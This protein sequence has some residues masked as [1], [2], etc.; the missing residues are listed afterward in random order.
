MA[1][2][3]VIGSAVN[4]G[5]TARMLE[6]SDVPARAIG[7]LTLDY[8]KILAKCRNENGLEVVAVFG[9]DF[10][11]GALDLLRELRSTLDARVRIHVLKE[12][13]GHTEPTDDSLETIR[14]DEVFSL[15][16]MRPFDA[17]CSIKQ[18]WFPSGAGSA[19]ASRV[20]SVARTGATV[21]RVSARTPTQAVPRGKRTSPLEVLTLMAQRGAVTT[22]LASE[23][24]KPERHPELSLQETEGVVSHASGPPAFEKMLRIMQHN[25]VLPLKPKVMSIVGKHG[26]VLELDPR[27]IKPLPDNPRWATNPGFSPESLRE[28]AEGIQL[29]GQAEAGEVCPIKGDPDFDAQLID[30]ERRLR[31]C[32]IA[33]VMFRA[34]VREDVTPDMLP[35]LWALSVVRNNGKVPQTVREQMSIVSRLRSEEFGLTVEQVATALG[36]GVGVV[37]RLSLLSRLH[38]LVQ[39]MLDDTDDSTGDLAPNNKG[40]RRGG[41]KLTSQLALLLIPFSPK[42]QVARAEEIVSQGMGYGEARRHIINHRREAGLKVSG[43]KKGRQAE[44]FQALSTL[45]RVSAEKFGIYLDMPQTEILDMIRGRS[46]EDRHSVAGELQSLA[47]CMNELARRIKPKGK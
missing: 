14:V 36:V 47:G 29:I 7:T 33:D 2:C 34:G 28:L 30:G 35:L 26:T 5:D 24:G 6:T 40:K 12:G 3:I 41:R 11:G 13:N 4:A 46:H 8:P 42:E 44:W 1:K 16:S 22:H 45:A 18:R 27:R 19:R 10:P 38:P 20:T 17:V 25:S 21:T 32:K 23:N 9:T 31:A 15:T 39:E 43:G 37:T